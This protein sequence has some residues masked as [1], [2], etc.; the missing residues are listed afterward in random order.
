MYG[1]LGGC[2]HLISS[3]FAQEIIRQ[4]M[5]NGRGRIPYKDLYVEPLKPLDEWL[6]CPVCEGILAEPCVSLCGHTFCRTCLEGL[7]DEN[8]E[9]TCP[10]CD[11]TLPDVVPEP[12][13]FCT[14]VLRSVM[15]RCPTAPA[16]DT[17]TCTAE[18]SLLDVE[19]HLNSCDYATAP[20]GFCEKPIARRDLKTHIQMAHKQCPHNKRGCKKIGDSSEI[21]QHMTTCPYEACIE[22]ISQLE[23]NQKTG[24]VVNDNR[25]M[26][27][28]IVFPGGRA[29]WA[30]FYSAYLTYVTRQVDHN[31]ASIIDCMIDSPN[32]MTDLIATHC[33]DLG[34][35][36]ARHA[37]TSAPTREQCLSAA[38]EVDDVMVRHCPSDAGRWAALDQTR[39]GGGGGARRPVDVLQV[40]LDASSS[41]NSIKSGQTFAAEGTGPWTVRGLREWLGRRLHRDISD[42]IPIPAN[43]IDPMPEMTRP[44]LI[45]SMEV[46]AGIGLQSKIFQPRTASS[47]LRTAMSMTDDSTS[48]ALPFLC[49]QFHRHHMTDPTRDCSTVSLI[50]TPGGRPNPSRAVLAAGR[51]WCG[52]ANDAGEA[53][54][55]WVGS[56]LITPAQW[57]R[58]PRVVDIV[59]ANQGW[60]ALTERGLFAWGSDEDGKL[61]LG[62]VGTV[63][64]PRPVSTPGDVLQVCAFDYI[65]FIRTSGGWFGCG[66][67]HNGE[68]GLGHTES[69]VVTP[70]PIPGSIDVTGWY[71]QSF[72]TLA[73]TE[74]N[75]LICGANGNGQLGIGSHA[76]NVSTLTDLGMIVD[77]AVISD[78]SALFRV[79]DKL[80]ISGTLDAPDGEMVDH[81]SPHPLTLPPHT[82][83]ATLA[84]SPVVRL[85]DGELSWWSGVGWVMC[86]EDGE[87]VHDHGWIA[88][89]DSD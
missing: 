64:R 87:L 74:N 11:F 84:S 86:E 54:L 27:A 77:S 35:I 30:M 44:A 32:D 70:T 33:A 59:G 19:M 89:N 57:V 48:A 3:R 22:Y 34:P 76:E 61:G 66:Y 7:I 69:P 51:V 24:E 88:V 58:L 65:T 53:G 56:S 46:T 25:S 10:V 72:V 16:Q 37:S 67:N 29:G 75:T 55:G 1:R 26:W 23:A 79:G 85:T 80:L 8:D 82:T 6:V 71:C 42:A 40:I 78:E 83:H 12:S 68:L 2:F 5:T 43:I 17:S 49:K 21:A 50:S 36:L 9:G 4:Q 45:Q 28:D 20:C 14:S 39:G 81:H 18:L 38:G 52:G 13:V 60:F 47:I 41:V 31:I 15:V 63:P 73:F 62:N